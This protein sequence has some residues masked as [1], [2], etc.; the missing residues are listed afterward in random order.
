ME[1]GS[2]HGTARSFFVVH[3]SLQIRSFSSLDR[4]L[5]VIADCCIGHPP[6]IR[7]E[8]GHLCA[9]PVGK[10][11]SPAHEFAGSRLKLA[12]CEKILLMEVEVVLPGMLYRDSL[13]YQ[14]NWA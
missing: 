4:W 13:S 10:R 6:R 9:A 11:P 3:S 8:I 7:R 12:V 1:V 5:F 14:S 2:R